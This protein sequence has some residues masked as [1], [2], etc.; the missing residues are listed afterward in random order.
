[1]FR[2]IIKGKAHQTYADSDEESESTIGSIGTVFTYRDAIMTGVD[3]NS[4]TEN[5]TTSTQV[6]N[7]PKQLSKLGQR[8]YSDI[9]SSIFKIKSDLQ[10]MGLNMRSD[11][12]H[13]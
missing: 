7:L 12:R 9:P 4:S 8:S 3:G 5:S 13:V 10:N 6:K 11:E 1:M 2:D